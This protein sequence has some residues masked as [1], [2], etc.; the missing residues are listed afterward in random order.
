MTKIKRKYSNITWMILTISL[1][2]LV[3]NCPEDP[4]PIIPKEDI[5]LGIYSETAPDILVPDTD[6]YIGTYSGGGGNISEFI[7]DIN[8]KKE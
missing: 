5:I 4:P 7:D 1:I 8:E 2:P 6:S 3:L